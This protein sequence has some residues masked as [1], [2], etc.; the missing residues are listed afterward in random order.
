MNRGNLYVESEKEDMEKNRAVRFRSDVKH[1]FPNRI[2]EP[3]NRLEE[4]LIC[5]RNVHYFKKK[6]WISIDM[7]TGQHKHSSSPLRYN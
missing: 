2:I 6:S 1:S 5:P 4:G 3:Q 7:E